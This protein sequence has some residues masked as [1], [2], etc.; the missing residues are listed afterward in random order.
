[1]YKE[2]DQAACSLILI[3]KIPE[4]MNIELYQVRQSFTDRG[5]EFREELLKELDRLTGYPFSGKSI[6]ITAGSRGITGIDS[7]TRLVVDF[8][9]KKGGY[10]FI[11]PA[12]GSHGGAT[13]EGQVNILASLGITEKSMSCPIKSSM[14]V[15]ELTDPGADI[16]VCIDKNAWQADGI[17]LI[18][19]IKPHTDFHD[20]YESGLVKMAAIGTGKKVQ[21]AEIHGRGSHGLKNVLPVISKHIFDTGKVIA[22]V[23]IVED[24]YDHTMLIRVLKTNEIMEQEPLLLQVARENMPRLPVNDIDILIVDQLGKNISG[25]GMDP[26]IIGRMMVQGEEETSDINIKRIMVDDLTNAS[27]GNALGIGLADVITRKLFN[28]INFTVMYE[29]IYTST[30]Y[31]RAWIPVIAEHAAD[32]YRY[33]HRGCHNIITGRERIIRIRDTMHLN[34]LF[35]SEAVL[36]DL[37]NKVEILRGPVSQFENRGK[38][39]GWY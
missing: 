1:M 24:A 19:R 23:A 29:N 12:M 21:A 37:R 38:L 16:P 4:M 18:N 31:E 3:L 26:N 11:F 5:I 39:C 13:A 28:K 20:R 15:V 8:V 35:V 10:P 34:D 17:I 6:A 32:A 27:L 7:I 2:Q 9:K 22:G 25:V 14:E 36:D 30:L 33:A